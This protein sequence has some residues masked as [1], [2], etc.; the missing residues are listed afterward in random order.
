MESGGIIER[1]NMNDKLIEKYLPEIAK[2]FQVGVNEAYPKVLSYI[3]VTSVIELIGMIWAFILLFHVFRYA[4]V[5]IEQYDEFDY[6]FLWLFTAL[7]MFLLLFLSYE[8]FTG[9]LKSVVNI[10]NPEFWIIDQVVKKI[11]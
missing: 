2:Q 8:L 5:K 9:I 4:K 11:S 6:V 3:R 10:F 1:N 7:G